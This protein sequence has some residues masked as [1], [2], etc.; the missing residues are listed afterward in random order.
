MT[1]QLLGEYR[2]A[3]IAADAVQ[4]LVCGSPRIQDDTVTLTLTRAQYDALNH[5]WGALCGIAEVYDDCIREAR[6]EVF[7]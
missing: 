3:S 6:K 1:N 7:A 5:L 4:P 2:L